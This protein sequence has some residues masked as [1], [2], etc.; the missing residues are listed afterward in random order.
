MP[1][2]G[3]RPIEA[4]MNLMDCS[5]LCSE[6]EIVCFLTDGHAVSVC[7]HYLKRQVF[8]RGLPGSNEY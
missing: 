7:P 3:A 5:C 6:V 4:K 2:A 8:A 1:A